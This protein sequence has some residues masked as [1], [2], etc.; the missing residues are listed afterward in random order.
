MKL[1][2]IAKVLNAK[3]L[4]CE[5]KVEDI[6]IEV[7]GASD[8]M[9]DVLLIAKPGMLL[10]T[11]LN[12]PQV[13]RTANIVGIPAVVIVRKKT[14]PPE[15]IDTAKNLGIVLLHSPIPMYVACGRLYE[16]KLKDVE[17]IIK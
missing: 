12:S 5:E 6:D 3:V 16:K 9:S 10:V 2:E 1:S 15:T 17:G 7:V 4:T 14:V 11:G 13:I 8:M